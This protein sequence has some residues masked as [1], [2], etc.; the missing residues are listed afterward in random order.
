MLIGV[1]IHAASFL[2]ISKRVATTGAEEGLL[3]IAFHPRYEK[4]RRFFVFYV[5]TQPGHDLQV[6]QFKHR[7]DSTVRARARSRQTTLIVPHDQANNHNGGQLQFGPDDHL[8]VS[9]GDGG[10]QRDPENDAQSSDSLLGKILR[11][12]P[13]EEGSYDIPKSNPFAGGP[14]RGEIF[15]TG[16]RNPYRFTFD[17]ETGAIAIGDV[18]LAAFEEVDYEPAGGALGANFGWNDYE[19]FQQ[20]TF[21]TAPLAD[22]HEPP[23]HAYSD[24]PGPCEAIT[25]GY[26]VRDPDL[27]TLGGRYIY[28]DYCG[29]PLRSLVPAEDGASDDASLGLSPAHVSSFGEGTARQLYVVSRDGP[30]YALEPTT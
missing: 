7:R 14:G 13:R 18:G 30:V 17:A 5:N 29:G 11:I 26:V 8:Y 4:N 16:L 27:P 22:P 28:A 9:T 6:D 20:T 19:G 21:G 10:P 1:D 2:D 24:A 3:S 25:G 15:A 12:S 23:I